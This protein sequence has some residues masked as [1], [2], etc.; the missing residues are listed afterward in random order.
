MINSEII[1]ELMRAAVLD[2]PPKLP[3]D[4]SINWDE[5][6]DYCAPQGILAW[7]W[8]SVCKLPQS[9]KPARIQSIN[10]ALSAQE[11]WDTSEK[12]VNVLKQII[13]KCD[14]NHIRV[15]LL[16]GIGLSNLYPKPESRSCGDIDIYLFGDYEKGN[17]ILGNNHFEETALHSELIYD[18]V[19][20]ENHKML[21]FPNT[22]TKK[23]VGNYLLDRLDQTCLM[24]NGYYVFSPIPNLVYLLMHT[25]NHISYVYTLPIISIR[26]LVDLAMFVYKNQ[27]N[28]PPQTCYQ[29]L[30]T[31]KMDKSFEMVICLSELLLDVD[32]SRYH[33]GLISNKDI[34][35]IQKFF[36]KLVFDKYVESSNVLEN[37]RWLWNR[38]R[39][40]LP[41]S[42]YIPRKPRNSLFYVTVVSQ[43]SIINKKVN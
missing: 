31:L 39:K 40:L 41:I 23:S 16:K 26:N 37:S 38:Y 30:K 13:E 22:K 33:Y 18:G 43:L 29:V 20:V 8:D 32:L 24:E 3:A 25:L 1:I 2:R 35:L 34:E 12:Q 19:T 5:L 28:L 6:M 4:I 21:I 17:M 14:N 36:L 10:W 42:R 15:L 11:I 7:V 27:S 9:Q